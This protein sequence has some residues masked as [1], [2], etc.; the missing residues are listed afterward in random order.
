MIRS[1]TRSIRPT[2][3]NYVA[4]MPVLTRQVTGR[5][6]IQSAADGE[7]SIGERD[8]RLSRLVLQ[9]GS[10]A[11]C[12]SRGACGRVPYPSSLGSPLTPN[13]VLHAGANYHIPASDTPPQ[14]SGFTHLLLQNEIPLSSTLSYLT[15]ASSLGVISTFNPSP[16]LT[17]GQLR[18]FPWQSLS[19]LIVNEGELGDLLQAFEIPL[20]SSPDLRTKAEKELLALHKSKSFHPDVSIICTLGAQ[21][22]LY[23]QPGKPVGHLP[24]AKL[25][26]PLRDTTG[27]GDCFAGYFVAGLMRGLELEQVLTTCLT[28]SQRASSCRRHMS[29]IRNG[30]A[31]GRKV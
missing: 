2:L 27:A 6:I 12:L 24:A 31:C 7:N 16:M 18:S 28:V 26:H 23:F 14:L 25:L 20:S 30:L 13:S 29:Q 21:G 3:P 15:A 10:D 19:W 9:L 5:A 11:R 8:G 22:I 1:V 4:L 17:P